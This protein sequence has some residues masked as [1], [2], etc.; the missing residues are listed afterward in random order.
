MSWSQTLPVRAPAAVAPGRRIYAIGDIHG[1]L[2]M[3]DALHRGIE[4]DLSARKVAE[5][6]L[7]HLGDYV[8]RGPDS[9]GVLERLLTPARLPACTIV[10]LMG[11]HEAML[12]QGLEGDSTALLDWLANGGDAT[13]ASWNIAAPADDPLEPADWLHRIP[14]AQ[15]DLLRQLPCSAGIDG[16][17]FAHAGVRPDRPIEAATKRDLLWMRE[18]FLSWAGRLE[19]VVVHGHTPTAS[20]AIRPH[21]IGIDTG[22]V[23]GGRLTC[24]VLEADTVSFLSVGA[25]A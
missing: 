21:R 11:N 10:N 16:Y 15:L 2:E 5:P 12:L 20:P 6:M 14:A 7:V 3:L 18:P 22:A 13:L 9:A 23:F 19:R 8:D 4:A 24:A 17:L 25:E 1:C